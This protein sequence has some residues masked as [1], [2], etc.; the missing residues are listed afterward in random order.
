MKGVYVSEPGGAFHIFFHDDVDGIISAALILRYVVRDR[1]Y[2]LRPVRTSQ[3]GDKFNKMIDD[4]DGGPND[5]LIIVDYQ[6]HKDADLWIDHHFNKTIGDMGFVDAKQIYN[7]RAKS[8]ARIIYDH[9]ATGPIGKFMPIGNHI[10]HMTDMIDSAGYNSVD[11]IFN[12]TVPMMVLK[13][14]LEQMTIFLDSTYCRIVEVISACDF[15]MEEALFVLGIDDTV[16][17]SLRRSAKNIE[18]AMVINGPVVITEMNRLYAFP[19]YAEYIAKPDAKYAFR[20]VHLGGGKIQTDIGF[21]QWGNFTNEVHIGEM[22]GSFDYTISGGGHHD[23]GG[24]IITEDKMERHIDD[25]TT[26][27]NPEESVAEAEMEKVGVDQEVDPVE[28]KAA[29]MVKTGEAGNIDKAR[30]KASKE[31]EGV[32]GN[33][34]SDID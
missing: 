32:E 3:R 2:T 24:S 5:E 27:L 10:V 25:I 11:Y 33:V 12:S 1:L 21:N 4:V 28:K 20:I 6:H 16:V 30:E 17:D 18:K 9:I 7:P 22:L 14:Y 8:A 23:V 29:E 26:I 13:A 19:R 31:K 15:D 34:Q